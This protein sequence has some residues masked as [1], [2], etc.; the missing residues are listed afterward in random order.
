[1]QHSPGITSTIPIPHLH[2]AEGFGKEGLAL[3]TL[4]I[5]YLISQTFIAASPVAIHVLHSPEQTPNL[6]G[7]RAHH[8]PPEDK[9]GHE[10]LKK[11]GCITLYCTP[12]G[13]PSHSLLRRKLRGISLLPPIVTHRKKHYNP[14]I[15][16]CS[17]I[18]YK[19]QG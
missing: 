11:A 5:I 18:G 13:N 1:M 12:S 19:L 9:Q 14:H 3:L 8:I 17:D 16:I 2:K 7:R 15:I 10:T 6:Y 4:P